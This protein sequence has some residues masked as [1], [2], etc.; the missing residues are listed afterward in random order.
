MTATPTN[1]DKARELIALSERDNYPTE[2]RLAAA[3]AGIGYALLAI[4]EDLAS[5]RGELAAV[6]RRRR[7]VWP[8]SRV[9]KEFDAGY[10]RALPNGGAQ[11]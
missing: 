4:H 3:Q 10:E 7:R 1:A 6:P 8:L 9:R 5:L 2:L 11:R